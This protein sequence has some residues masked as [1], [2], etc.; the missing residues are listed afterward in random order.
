M[1]LHYKVLTIGDFLSKPFILFNYADPLGLTR[2]HY[3]GGIQL[4]GSNPWA[5]PDD[6]ALI[7]AF[8]GDTIIGRLGG[9]A[10]YAR[11]GGRAERVMCLSGFVLNKDYVSSGAG[12]II[13]LYALKWGMPLSVCG[14]PS[15]QLHK[16]YSRAGFINLCPLQRFLYFY[17]FGVIAARYAKNRVLTDALKIVSDPLLKLYY[18]VR[19]RVPSQAFIFRGVTSF[20]HELDSMIG[21]EAKNCFPKS[22]AVLNWAM[23]HRTLHAFEIRRG[24]ILTG[25]CLLKRF[26]LQANEMHH[27]P[28][29]TV[30]TL[31]DY[32][33]ADDSAEAKFSIVSFAVNFFKGLDVDVFEC[34]V[35]DA[36][37][38][39][40]CG[41]LGMIH[42]GGYKMFFKPAPGV[43]LKDR[44]PW[45]LTLATGDMLIMD[46]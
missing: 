9:Y 32:Y 39:Q 15:P 6:P 21:G 35:S 20:N 10:G 4:L 46:D 17:T 22:A 36:G 42:I 14:G 41:C 44:E 33:I 18:A 11:Y 3:T 40:S 8:D 5:K 13:L 31:L 2:S 19:S 38:A 37:M 23:K 16:V 1:N 28:Q 26:T 30:G 12:G 24:Q 29:M 43:K 45:F 7:L 27:L 25:Y 34:Q